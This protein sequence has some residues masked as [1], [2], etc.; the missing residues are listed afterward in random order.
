MSAKDSRFKREISAPLSGLL[1][2]PVRIRVRDQSVSA[3]SPRPRPQFVRGRAPSTFA[4]WPQTCPCPVHIRVRG[5]SMSSPSPWTDHGR[6]L[7]LIV[8]SPNAW[9]VRAKAKSANQPWPRFVNRRVQSSSKTN[10]KAKT[11]RELIHRYG[12][13]YHII[14]WLGPSKRL[15]RPDF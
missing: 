5:Q 12:S 3:A 4:T 14:L 11:V 9:P 2:C 13:R 8:S 7:S 10:P 6:N 1:A 15:L